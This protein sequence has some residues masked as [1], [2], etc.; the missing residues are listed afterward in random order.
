MFIVLGDDWCLSGLRDRQ[1]LHGGQSDLHRC[2]I[3]ACSSISVF[4]MCGA[5]CGAMTYQATAGATSTSC[6]GVYE[7]VFVFVF[8]FC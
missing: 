6:T 1:F 7:C 4:V 2:V 3:I 5:A 8:N